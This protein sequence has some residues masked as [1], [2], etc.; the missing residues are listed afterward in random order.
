MSLTKNLP[1]RRKFGNASLAGSALV[2]T[3]RGGTLG[4]NCYVLSSLAVSSNANQNFYWLLT[5]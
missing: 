5:P 1:R 2:F 4:M 3:G